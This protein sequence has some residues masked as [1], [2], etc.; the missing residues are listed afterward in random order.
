M[1]HNFQG[2]DSYFILQYLREQGVMSEVITRGGKTL[3]LKVPMLDIRFVDSLNFIPMKLAN[4]PK[5][6]GIEELATKDT[7]LTSSTKKKM[8]ITSVR[9]RLPRI[10]VPIGFWHGTHSK[11]RA[12]TSST[13]MKKSYRIVDPMWTFYAVAVWNFPNC[14]TRLPT[15]IRSVPLPL[16]LRTK[17][18]RSKYPPKDTIAIIHPMGYTPKAALHCSRSCSIV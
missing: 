18:Y 8:K 2:Y 3:S 4:F 14:F 11:K 6:F 7:F 5:T 10:T 12:I 1:A 16:R 15:S 17:V 13:L 9:F